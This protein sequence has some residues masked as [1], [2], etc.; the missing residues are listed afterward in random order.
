MEKGLIRDLIIGGAVAI[1]VALASY[2]GVSE[3]LSEAFYADPENPR[4]RENCYLSGEDAG[5]P[6]TRADVDCDR[7]VIGT[8]SSARLIVPQKGNGCPNYM[9]RGEDG[10][11]EYFPP[12]YSN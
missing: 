2:Q 10:T 4:K 6:V 11:C 8:G 3:R 1:P 9:Q 7:I 5:L 12:E